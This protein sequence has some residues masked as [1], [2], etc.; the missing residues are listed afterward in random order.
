MTMAAAQ[1]HPPALPAELTLLAARA[2]LLA[3]WVD[4]RGQPRRVS[5]QTLRTLLAALGL[6]ASSRDDIRDSLRTLA[7][8]KAGHDGRFRI[9]LAGESVVLP[10]ARPGPYVL[11]GEDGARLEGRLRAGAGE[12][13]R[14]AV[15]ATPGYYR[16]RLTGGPDL[17]LAVAPKA[18]RAFG[19]LSGTGCAW[20]LAAQVY[21]LRRDGPDPA[22]RTL[23]HGDF[24]AVRDLAAR[25]A[26]AGA[27]VLALSPVHAM[28]SADPSLCSPYSPS[29]RL[30]LNVLYADPAAVLGEDFVRATLAGQPVAQWIAWDRR[31]LIDWQRSGPARLAL[32]RALHARFLEHPP[33]GLA[34][35]YAE[36][37]RKAGPT[38]ESHA[39]F[40]ALHATISAERGALTP[41]PQW[42]SALRTPGSPA[43]RE[44][45]ARH[46]REI[47]FHRF[48]QW[49]A[50]AS[51]ARAQAEARQGG[52]RVGL[53]ADLAIGCSP[54]GSQTWSRPGEHVR[55]ACVGA[56]PDVYNAAGQAWGLAA[57]SPRALRERGYA[58]YIELLRA[59]LAHAGGV[60][61]DHV[62]GLSRL[63]LV[64]DGADPGDG[65]YLRYPA[66][67]LLR[68][69][70]LEAWR[71]RALV[72]G[73][74]LGTV[75]AGFDDT[76]RAHGVAGMNVLWFLRETGADGEPGAFLPPRAW[77]AGAVG[78]AS[79]HDLPT[80]CGWWTG[81]D[82]AWKR[83][84]GVCADAGAERAKR[85][86][87]R[88]ALWRALC[89]QAR[90]MPPAAPP[91]A[92]M[93]RHVAS[94]AGALALIA[95]EDMEGMRSQPNLPGT[96]A[97]QHP[98]WRRRLPRD[99][100]A[101][102]DS[103]DFLER[104][105][106]VRLGRRRP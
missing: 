96:A 43:L 93:L 15:P 39:L 95:M 49:L 55:H 6:E 99:A 89:P 72:I 24:G 82:I 8:E 70:A 48:A 69:T 62:L 101:S 80:L 20:G 28:F 75:P 23:G 81:R 35:R 59:N 42:D 73:E 50:D 33:H 7:R 46:A 44:F 19:P 86:D 97:G 17:V 34:A 71:Q 100:A 54:L 25:A 32:L 83:R 5:P 84:A 16:L 47:D 40:E 12:S 2:G 68:L 77:P 11:E 61:I 10:S 102:F 18:P 64:P 90:D 58:P 60:R 4:A 37:R 53:L 88:L 63:W 21:S 74:N 66:E 26:G 57:T 79:T 94:S 56:P 104:L 38:L 3:D 9:V 22:R 45:A 78:M 29:N 65:A 27:D 76:L 13:P 106:A 30:L 98:N 52:M 87:D 41:W 36:F 105:D 14:L 31:R 92:R 91:L 67:D 85:H 103:P 51:L 1:P